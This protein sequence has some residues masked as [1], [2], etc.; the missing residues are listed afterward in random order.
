MPPPGSLR[1]PADPH[2]VQIDNLPRSLVKS[3]RTTK[4]QSIWHSGHFEFLGRA[5]ACN[6][7]VFSELSGSTP[8]ASTNIDSEEVLR[9]PVKKLK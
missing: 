1:P 7:C 5:D 8:A 2:Q 9:L 3:C 4:V 6:F